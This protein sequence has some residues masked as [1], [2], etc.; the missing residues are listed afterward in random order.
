MPDQGPPPRPD[1]VTVRRLLPTE[2]ALVSRVGDLVAG[3]YG[4]E[5]HV[6]GGYLDVLRRADQ[7]VVA[8]EVLVA[9]DDV[10]GE[11]L[12]TVT[13][14]AG[15]GP[16]SNLAVEGEAEFRMLAVRPGVRRRGI[17]RTL[18]DACI[19]RAGAAGARRLRLSSGPTMVDAHRLYERLGFERTPE[20][21][22]QPSPEEPVLLTYALDLAP[23]GSGHQ[24]G[25]A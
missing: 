2:T 23:A 15:P 20:R 25:P 6:T 19:A 12:G 9:L 21:D 13:F 1:G 5:G 11:L 7:R 10:A 4:D 8:A 3:V 18:V 17:G 16:L 22:W 14:S 24:T